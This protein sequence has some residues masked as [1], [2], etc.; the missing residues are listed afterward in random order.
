M[1]SNYLKLGT[2][3]F[4]LHTLDFFMVRFEKRSAQRAANLSVYIIVLVSRK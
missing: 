2:E 3:P 1:D 4:Y